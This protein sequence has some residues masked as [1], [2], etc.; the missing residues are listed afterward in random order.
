VRYDL[1][2]AQFRLGEIHRELG[3]FAAAEGALTK[4]GELLVEL[5]REQPDVAEYQRDM[6]ASYAALGLVYLDTAR[7]EKAEAVFE[8]VLAIQEKQAEAYPQTVEYRYALA[9][10]YRAFGFMLHRKVRPAMAA[11]SSRSWPKSTPTC[12]NMLTMSAVALSNWA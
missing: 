2:L 4:A 11:K 9:K 1:G 10:T 3:D 5:V 12:S 6:A 8:P 7:W